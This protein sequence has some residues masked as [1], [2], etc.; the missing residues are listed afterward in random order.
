MRPNLR[1]YGHNPTNI[2][3]TDTNEMD[4]NTIWGFVLI[5]AILIGFSF[6][7]RPSKEQLAEQQRLRDSIAHVEQMKIEA[8]ALAREA[9]AIY[10][11]QQAA[12]EAADTAAA[13]KRI[14]DMY[15]AFAPAAVGTEQYTVLENDLVRLNIS[16]KGGRIAQA[17]LKEYKAWGDTVNDLTL[18]SGDESM[19]N[20][21][22]ITA[23]NRVLKTSDLYFTPQGI[24]TLADS[25]QVLTMRLFTAD[26]AS[27]IDVTYLLPAADYMARMQIQASKMDKILAHNVNSLEMQWNQKIRQQEQGRKFENQYSTLQYMFLGDDTDKLS[28]TSDDSEDISSRLRWIAYKDQFF[29]TVMIADDAFTST[30]LTSTM[31]RAPYIKEYNTITSV[32]FDPTGK[33]ATDFRLYL[34]PNHY[35]TLKAYDEGVE[36]D[37]RLHLQDLVPLGWSAVSWIDKV[38]VIPMFDIFSSWGIHIGWIIVL[39]TL[40]IK[41]IIFPFTWMS[42]KST[43]KMRVLKPQIEAINAKYPAEK[44]QE[45]QQ[46]TMALYSKY[47]V[48]PMSGCLPMLLQFPFLM[49]MF[50]FFPTAIELRGQS[51]FWAQDLS[52][53]DAVI[54]WSGHIPIISWIFGN[55]LSLFCLLMTITNIAYTYFNMQNQQ[56]GQE[57]KAMKWMMYL[58]PLMFLF[59]FNEYAAGLS[60]YYL[61]SMLFTII[62]TL[63]LRWTTNDEKLLKKM[64]ETVAKKGKNPK[65][66]GFMARLEQMQREQQAYAR[67]QAKKRSPR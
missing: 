32:S 46:A 62:Q 6:F 50:W 48:S 16:N 7:N 67:E 58:M 38:L 5:A 26:S 44:M 22:L 56:T 65:K 52:T 11:A 45:R 57:M 55:H 18:F 40:V 63:V 51:L 34:G 66:S 24:Q 4:K 15:G 59:I 1:D 41:L 31:M 49:A 53:Y 14:H 23:N 28:E 8:E 25:T 30:Q 10:E 61:V 9:Q 60:F 54:T 17:E 27:H 3:E 43:A 36:K 20:F 21:L 35:N 39:M 37:A 12:A 42:Y 29:S 64:E 2:H 13:A 33:E 47:G 19:L